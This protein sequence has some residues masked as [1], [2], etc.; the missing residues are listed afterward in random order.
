MTMGAAL[1]KERSNRFTS[2][3]SSG[4]PALAVW[5]TI[6]WPSVLE[7]AGAWGIDAAIID[8]EHTSMGLESL[9]HMLVAAQR[10]GVTPIV[11]P[12]DLE[13]TRTGRILDAGAEGILFP[14]I[15]DGDAAEGARRSLRHAPEGTRGWGGAH[16]R[17]ALWQ[18]SS[19]IDG[20]LPQDRGVY[21]QEYVDKAARDVACGFLIESV[22]GVENI[23]DILDRG[24]PDVVDF[25]RGDFSVEVGFD[26][27]RCD[28]AFE[29]VY[30]AC[31]DRG[32][33]VNIAPKQLAR[34]YFPGCYSVVGMDS[35]LLSKAIEGAARDARG[36]LA[37]RTDS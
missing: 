36:A 28:R 13:Q 29:R 23:D 19:A 5:V 4:E 27:S 33:G 8:L 9:E 3:L 20:Q 14:R 1:W 17:H 32:I 37:A 7:I 26:D 25:G 31:R 24:Q 21:S 15:D 35:L 2:L 10:A 22:A 34:W 18:G 16:T 11:R 30:N 12:P 6:P